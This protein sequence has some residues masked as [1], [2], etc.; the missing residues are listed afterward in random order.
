M[1]S[2]IVVARVV[3]GFVCMYKHVYGHR[4]YMLHTY[5]HMQ[6]KVL[7]NLSYA[8]TQICSCMCHMT[9]AEP[10]ISSSVM[11]SMT[12]VLLIIWNQIIMRDI[13]NFGYVRRRILNFTYKNPFHKRVSKCHL[14]ANNSNCYFGFFAK[15]CVAPLT[16]CPI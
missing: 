6:L 7:C 5:C 1:I 4:I 14:V 3:F 2:C 10:K 16:C 9:V 8:T 15:T 11:E 13:N 12:N